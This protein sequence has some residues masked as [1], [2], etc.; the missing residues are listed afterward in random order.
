MHS[1]F[2]V[3][4]YILLGCWIV[5]AVLVILSPQR[6]FGALSL[7]RISLPVRLVSFFRVLGALNAVGSVYLIIRYA[8]G[9]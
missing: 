3:V 5:V 4:G 8:T 2:G 9:V 1:P 6:F 7:G